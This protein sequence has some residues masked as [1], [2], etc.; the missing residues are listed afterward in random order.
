MYTKL[1]VSNTT[2]VVVQTL[3]KE[4][5]QMR[6]WVTSQRDF[7]H[8]FD[9]LNMATIRLNLQVLGEKPETALEKMVK[10][11]IEEVPFRKMELEMERDEAKKGLSNAEGAI[12]FLKVHAIRQICDPSLDC[13]NVP[14]T[15]SLFLMDERTIILLL[16]IYIFTRSRA[17][18]Q[19][20]DKEIHM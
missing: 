4:Y 12:R 6:K 3:R 10:V 17:N 5:G 11:S 18:H 15:N 7:L 14:D 1:L 13:L 8:A 16:T 20:A 9:E 2:T 19:D